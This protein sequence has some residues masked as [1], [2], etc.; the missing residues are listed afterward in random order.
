MPPRGRRRPR[1][2]RRSARAS[3]A[4]RRS[5][6]VLPEPFGPVTSEE[7]AALDVEVDSRED[8]L[9][10]VALRQ[11]ARADHSEHVREHEERRRRR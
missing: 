9:L 5:S 10:A 8:A 6:V 2:R 4:Q 1:A 3:P 11:P 7:A